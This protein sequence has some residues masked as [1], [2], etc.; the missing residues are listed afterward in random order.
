MV[1]PV[2]ILEETWPYFLWADLGAG[3]KRLR[4]VR[5]ER[6]VKRGVEGL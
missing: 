1:N 5:L 6:E 3:G 2:L 4:V